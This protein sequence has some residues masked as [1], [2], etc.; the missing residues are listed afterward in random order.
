MKTMVNIQLVF[1]RA[2]N[3]ERSAMSTL[4]SCKYEA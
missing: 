3:Y 1:Y 4:E 2:K